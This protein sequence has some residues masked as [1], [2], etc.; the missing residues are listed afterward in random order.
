MTLEIRMLPPPIQ[1][2]DQAGGHAGADAKA[3]ELQQLATIAEQLKF[4]PVPDKPIIKLPPPKPPG[5]RKNGALEQKPSSGKPK[6]A[7]R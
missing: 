4:P 1:P 6:D 5:E 3:A 7:K 2:A